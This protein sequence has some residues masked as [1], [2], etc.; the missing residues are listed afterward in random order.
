M[1]ACPISAWP[2]RTSR[3]ALSAE[4]SK[5]KVEIFPGSFTAGRV[6]DKIGWDS[7]T[8]Q[9]RLTSLPE[10]QSVRASE[11]PR[12]NLL[13][14]NPVYSYLFWP[15]RHVA[16]RATSGAAKAKASKTELPTR[17]W[18]VAAQP[19]YSPDAQQS[20]SACLSI[21]C[22]AM[23]WAQNATPQSGAHW[24]RPPDHTPSRSSSNKSNHDRLGQLGT[25]ARWPWSGRTGKGN[26]ACP[27]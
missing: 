3:R 12:G 13:L 23:G 17:V 26:A 15:C 1:P 20:L 7:I 16:T 9:S 4:R 2:T 10:G 25:A 24:P 14:K 5:K 27:M 19:V 21:R 11:R 18:L 22:L 8:P 6:T